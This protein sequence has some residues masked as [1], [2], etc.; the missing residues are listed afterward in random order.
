MPRDLGLLWYN[1]SVLRLA[2]P[3]LLSPSSNL[4]M[5][6]R[7]A[8]PPRE[9]GPLRAKGHGVQALKVS[10]LL[11]L[12]AACVD[13]PVGIGVVNVAV[14][15]AGIDTVWVGAPGEAVPAIRLRVT[16]NEGRPFSGASL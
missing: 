8:S 11:I 4:P 3:R 14:L 15:G 1:A 2:S 6:L 13:D 5:L 9:F 10:L 7:P 12:L 16:D